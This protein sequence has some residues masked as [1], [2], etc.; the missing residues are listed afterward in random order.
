MIRS[1]R[2]PAIE[3]VGLSC[4]HVLSGRLTPFPAGATLASSDSRWFLD[5]LDMIDHIGAD[6]VMCSTGYPHD[7]G[8]HGYV[9]ETIRQVIETVSSDE[10][11][12]IPGGPAIQLY[13]LRDNRPA[14]HASAN[15]ES[16]LS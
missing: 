10:S 7:E 12:M 6:R 8:N 13:G 15:A 2:I 4:T 16:H 14:P 3:S 5:E 1:T 9:G 11:C